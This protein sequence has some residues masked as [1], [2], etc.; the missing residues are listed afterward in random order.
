MGFITNSG[1]HVT[2]FSGKGRRCNRRREEKLT[3]IPWLGSRR[4]RLLMSA[5]AKYI[6]ELPLYTVV[7]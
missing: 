1:K 2:K 6:R 5:P 4:S 7:I 3:H